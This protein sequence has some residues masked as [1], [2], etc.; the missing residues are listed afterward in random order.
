MSH[1]RTEPVPDR[2][3][4]NT[5]GLPNLS[6]LIGGYPESKPQKDSFVR[7]EQ[8]ERIA[9]DLLAGQPVLVRGV[10]RMG[11]TSMVKS[12]E[13]HFFDGET[14]YLEVRGGDETGK[15][16]PIEEYRQTFGLGAVADLICQLEN[17][18]L[19]LFAFVAAKRQLSLE[20][21]L[22]LKPPFQYLD[23]YLGHHQKTAFVALD[24]VISQSHDVDRFRHIAELTKYRNLRLALVIHCSAHNEDVI[25]EVFA[26]F[27]THFVQAISRA[28]VELLV[29]TPLEGTG[30]SLSDDAIDEIIKQSGSR[31]LEINHICRA[32]LRAAA[33]SERNPIKVRIFDGD[34]VRNLMNMDLPQLKMLLD[35][36][37]W[38]YEHVLQA[39]ISDQERQLLSRIASA[40]GL[41]TDQIVSQETGLIDRLVDMTYVVRDDASGQYRINGELLLRLLTDR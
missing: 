18:G 29:R 14:L 3:H 36:V 21:R 13:T 4:N 24:E 27:Q 40:S 11:K 38:N 8:E 2:P 9:V 5:D 31:P 1:L 41:S 23:D 25:A 39:A 22:S 10:T 32:L 35:I 30:I 37:F 33:Q 6:S 34:D 17:P 26:D 28:D 20:I 7:L 12:I 19:S 15:H 16:T